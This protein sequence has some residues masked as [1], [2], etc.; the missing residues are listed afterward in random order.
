MNKKQKKIWVVVWIFLSI[1]FSAEKSYAYLDL[2]TGQYILQ[3]VVAGF[4][5]L[6]FSLK[7]YWVKFTSF[8]KKLFTMKKI[9]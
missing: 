3:I 9:K 8:L 4:V 7:I 2:G 5:G 1:I 6:I